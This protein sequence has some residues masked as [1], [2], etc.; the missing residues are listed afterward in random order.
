MKIT[1]TVLTG[2]C[3]ALTALTLM[4]GYAQ[5]AASSPPPRSVLQ[6]Q[7]EALV[8]AGAPGVNVEVRDEKGTWNGVAGTGDT[9]TNSAPNAGGKF[10]IGSVT[11]TFTATV[12]MQL[13]AEKH[14]E[15]D[16]SINEYLPGLLPYAE[17]ISVRQLLRHQSGLFDYG[18][19][20][21]ASPQVAY[22]NRNNNYAPAQLVEI[23]TR[24]PLQFTPG[25]QFGYSNTDY[26]V[27]AMLIE[28]VTDH[29]FAT[30]LKKRIIRP[31]KLRDT[32]LAGS[33]PTL[34]NPS[35]RGYETLS[36][37]GELTDVT[38]YNMSVSWA[39]GAIT[40]TTSDVNR[41]YK[42]LL[43]GSL[44]PKA[45]LQQMKETVDAFPGFGYGLG[46]AG[47][48]ICGHTI[49]G[50]VGGVPGYQTSSFT[51]DDGKRQITISTNRSLSQPSTAEDATNSLLATEFCGKP[52]KK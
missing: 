38:R 52:P 39:T 44:L 30:E 4:T 3:A 11:K 35:M 19:V 25:S 13:V 10:R 23:A 46:L 15:L 18:D 1:R 32:S 51:S 2:G 42:A 37:A 29:S 16:A 49:W 34:K 28:K 45:Q 21:W 12:I 41:F 36:D 9:T 43:T 17:P 20:V 5:A 24:E 14:I 40:S 31:L 8:A 22:D 7:M 27:L 48:E 26:I 33:S 6:S 47:G 50:H